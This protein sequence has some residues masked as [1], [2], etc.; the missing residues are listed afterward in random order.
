MAN[1]LHVDIVSDVVCPWCMI[2]WERLKKAAQQL[3]NE[4]ELEIRWRPFEL[5]PQMAAEGV[6]R[7][8]YLA[9]KFGPDRMRG[10]H[11]R[12][13]GVAAEDGI[14]VDF[15]RITRQPRTLDAHR[16]IDWRSSRAVVRP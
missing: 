14:E 13:S 15:A 8:T 11:D 6:D 3:E 10:M 5:N 7:A 2:G 9:A 1:T 16:L 12:L 4:I